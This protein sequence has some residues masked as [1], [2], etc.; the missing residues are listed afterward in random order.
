L[1]EKFNFE[2]VSQSY[3]IIEKA[4]ESLFIKNYNEE[5]EEICK[6][7]E[8]KQFITREDFRL[9]QEFSIQVYSNFLR[10][11]RDKYTETIPGF[12][13]WYGGYDYKTGIVTTPIKSDEYV[14]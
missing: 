10:E 14:V 12:K 13:V 1:R 3:R 2:T 4:T 6:S 11:T 7:I 9:I 5:S 8:K